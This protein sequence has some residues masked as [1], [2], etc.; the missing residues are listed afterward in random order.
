MHTLLTDL[1]RD[2]VFTGDLAQDVVRFLG[3]HGYPKT[4]T[5]CAAV[6]D[7]AVRIATLVGAD[8]A[9]AEQAA[10]LHDVSA[11]F[12]AAT[13]AHVAETLGVEVLL[14]EAALPMILHQKLSAVLAREVFSVTNAA[15]LSAVG[16]HTTLK[17]RASTLDEVIFVADK[18]A[19]DQPGVPPYR[20]GLVQALDRSLDDAACH[21]LRYLWERRASLAVIHPWFVAACADL[22]GC[23]GK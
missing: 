12:P 3:D 21:Y 5:H 19:W 16:C 11:V 23:A 4:V 1:V 10:W 6:A 7:E 2:V 15:V 18:L 9:L 13:R 8:A 20:D 22:C 17:A 14:E